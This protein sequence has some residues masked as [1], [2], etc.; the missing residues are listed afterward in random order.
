LGLVANADCV[1][2][3]SNQ[4]NETLYANFDSNTNTDGFTF[5]S[6]CTTTGIINPLLASG[7]RSIISKATCQVNIPSGKSAEF[8]MF[9]YGFDG[10]L[11]SAT[12][13]NKYQLGTYLYSCSQDNAD[14]TLQATNTSAGLMLSCL[15]K[16]GSSISIVDGAGGSVCG[17]T[18][19]T[20]N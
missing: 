18:W 6:G 4:S 19:T 7:S 15:T 11:A 14:V 2:D 3:I 1:V 5:A 16:K 8:A 17:G 20:G 13:N 10:S 12:D 9:N